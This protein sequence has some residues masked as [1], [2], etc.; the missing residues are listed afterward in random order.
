MTIS[1]SKT[2]DI[3]KDHFLLFKLFCFVRR[4]NVDFFSKITQIEPTKVTLMSIFCWTDSIMSS[5]SQP[6]LIRFSQGQAS[7]TLHLS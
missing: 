2:S 5:L 7:Q 6:I 3:K 1:H 4:S